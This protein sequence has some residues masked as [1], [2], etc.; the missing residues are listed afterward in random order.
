MII[1]IGNRKIGR[2]NLVFIVAEL[3]AN[4]CQDFDLAVKTIEA[5]AEAG[6]DAVK[7]QTYTADTMT[8]DSHKPPFQIKDKDS[9]WKGQ[10][11]YSLYK[12]AYTPWEW[13]PKL[14][15]IAEDLGL[16]CFSTPFDKTAVD[17]LEEEF[18]PAVYKIASF[19]VVD[20]PLIEYIAAKRKPII[21]STGATNLSE[22]KEAVEACKKQGN[23][24]IAILKCTSSYPT[25]YEEINLKT[26]TDIEKRF[27]T[28]VGISDHSLG[29]AVA[30]AAVALGARIIEKHFIL[31]KKLPGADAAFSL[32]PK[33]L[34]EMINAVRQVEKSLG[35][36]DYTPGKEKRYRRS[37]FIVKDVK[38]SEILTDQNV[39]SIRPD[40][41]LTPK[42]LPEIMG[43]RAKKDIKR[44]TP[45]NWNLI[46]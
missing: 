24:Q 38:R 39:R 31:D 35:K 1:K 34:R 17:F 41:G 29:I 20:I 6:A 15:K 18:K 9:L 4:H 33:E 26:I 14:K 8:I 13:Q 32:D 5:A 45:L 28:V 19:E 40:N 7:L 44:G 30:V 12:K 23:D 16:I 25:K 10:T 2:N 43:K 46:E 11:L 22:L 42:Y 21:M 3:S 27:K 37:L 36:A